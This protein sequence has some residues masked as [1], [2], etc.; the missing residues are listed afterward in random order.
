MVAAVATAAGREPIV[1]GLFLEFIFKRVLSCYRIKNAFDLLY[2][3][4]IHH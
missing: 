1:L 2:K 4:I 3:Y